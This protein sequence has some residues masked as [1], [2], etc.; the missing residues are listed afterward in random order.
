MCV[1]MREHRGR[2]AVGAELPVRV[3]REDSDRVDRDAELGSDVL[4]CQVAADA[5][6]FPPLVALPQ[7]QQ[8]SSL[9]CF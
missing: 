5:L 6:A 9:S 4:V 7:D 2:G 3:H 8:L 1:T